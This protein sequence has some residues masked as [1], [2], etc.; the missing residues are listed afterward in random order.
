M[1]RTSGGAELDIPANTRAN[2]TVASSDHPYGTVQ[3]SLPLRFNVSESA[4]R[5]NV[6]V[7]RTGGQIG[8]LHVSYTSTGSTA[9]PGVDFS[10]V[11]GGE[12]KFNR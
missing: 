8:Q 7:T 2:I 6:T 4:G 10:P 5:V 3:F 9:T 11:Q 12:L 1:E